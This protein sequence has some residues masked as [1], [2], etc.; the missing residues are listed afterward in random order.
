MV[1]PGGLEPPT[2]GLW[3]LWS[4]K[5]HSSSV[6]LLKNALATDSLRL[7]TLKLI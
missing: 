3:G 1:G 4:I 7:T 2:N 6:E 5:I